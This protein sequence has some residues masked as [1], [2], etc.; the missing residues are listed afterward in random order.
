MFIPNWSFL[1]DSDSQIIEIMIAAYEFL[2][3]ILL[4]ILLYCGFISK[5]KMRDLNNKVVILMIVPHSFLMALLPSFYSLIGLLI[6]IYLGFNIR[7]AKV[8]IEDEQKGIVSVN[9][10]SRKIEEMR[11]KNL[12]EEE[13]KI[14]LNQLGEFRNI[15]VPKIFMLT[16]LPFL[17][18]VYFTS[19]I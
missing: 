13:K 17:I 11:F 3:L 5:W 6:M 8:I 10:K 14:W 1:L 16:T 9:E 15:P 19:F 18:G 4:M 2:F 7:K 12:N